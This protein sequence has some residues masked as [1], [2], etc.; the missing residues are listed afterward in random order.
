MD[1]PLAICSATTVDYAA[2]TMA[3]D[4]VDRDAAFENT[5]VHFNPNQK[6]Y[7]LPS[8]MPFEVL[9]FKNADSE[10]FKGGTPGVSSTLR[11]Y[12]VHTNSIIRGA[13]CVI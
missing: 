3:G 12:I 9:L 13:T 5:Q 7:Y 11:L 1:W 6:W 4:V 10:E 8:Q 2:D